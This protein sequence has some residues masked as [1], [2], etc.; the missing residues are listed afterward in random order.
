MLSLFAIY[1]FALSSTSATKQLGEN[2]ITNFWD[3]CEDCQRLNP[4]D[5]C[6]EYSNWGEP[7][8]LFVDQSDGCHL[9]PGK[10]YTTT[11]RDFTEDANGK[12]PCD[13]SWWST[14]FAL[15]QYDGQCISGS[16]NCAYDTW[17]CVKEVTEATVGFVAGC[18]DGDRECRFEIGGEGSECFDFSTRVTN[19]I[20]SEQDGWKTDGLISTSMYGH[21]GAGMSLAT[22]DSVFAVD[23]HSKADI[24]MDMELTLTR[25]VSASGSAEKFIELDDQKKVFR[26]FMLVN[27]LPV[28]AEVFVQPFLKLAWEGTVSADVQIDFNGAFEFII[29]PNAKIDFKHGGIVADSEG[30]ECPEGYINVGDESMLC[31][32]KLRDGDLTMSLSSSLL[33][34]SEFTIALV[35]EVTFELNRFPMAVRTEIPFT[36][37]ADFLADRKG[38]QGSVSI[39]GGPSFSIGIPLIWKLQSDLDPT[40]GHPD[41]DAECHLGEWKTSFQNFESL[42]CLFGEAFD[43]V[44]CN[45]NAWW[46]NFSASLDFEWPEDYVLELATWDSTTLWGFSSS[47]V[48]STVD[49]GCYHDNNDVF[50]CGKI[51]MR[52]MLRQQ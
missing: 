18:A 11:T 34:S 47:G 1:I 13:D 26:K 17:K 5:C 8:N 4:G 30:I 3:G 12:K 32:K 33:A 10:E 52:R 29:A 37:T 24:S 44:I 20:D 43:K 35:P 14:E 45:I 42:I 7:T 39:S 6:T 50:K 49:V 46:D 9:C 38:T 40:L 36:L 21:M 28:L 25:K 19:A 22:D 48:L 23:V 27:N 31:V 41:F 2:F 16:Q 15:S 51:A